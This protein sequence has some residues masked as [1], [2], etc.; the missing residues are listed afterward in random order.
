MGAL[1]GKAW[2]G[3]GRGAVLPVATLLLVMLMVVPVPAFLLDVGFVTNI[4]ISLA[5]LMVA[6]NVARPL[7]FSSFPT[8]LLF[9]TLFRLA[10]NVASTRVVLVNGHEGSARRRPCDR[11]VRQLPDRRRLCGRHLRLPDPD[12]HQPG[13]HHQG[14]GP[15]VRSLGALHP[16]RHARQADGDRRRSQRRPA[17]ARGSQGAAAGGRD[18][19][20]FLRLDGR[21]LQVREGR[22]GRRRAD[23][24]RQRDRRPDPRH[25]QPRHDDRRRRLELHPARDRRRAGR[26]G[27]GAAAV[28]RRRLDRHPGL[29]AARPFGADRQPVRLV[30]RLD[31]GRR[32]PRHSRPAAGHAALHHPARRRA[33]PASSPGS[34]AR[35]SRRAPSR[36][37][38]PRRSPSTRARSAGTRSAT[39]P[40]WGSK[41]A[42]A[43]SAWSTSARARR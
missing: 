8:V 15:R 42:S 2:L 14:R 24:R 7:D 12:D 30:A 43:W 29:L 34:C 17:D 40:L 18:R 28:D 23:P 3:A 20:R 32:N 19:G 39:T 26:A 31:S 5:V 38:R 6:L 25:A 33:S 35:P 9:A 22:R 16:R 27:A 13:R 1:Q 10:L 21:R 41:W 36:R 37:S 4:M 11:G